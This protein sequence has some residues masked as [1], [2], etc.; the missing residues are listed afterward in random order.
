MNKSARRREPRRHCGAEKLRI[1]RNNDFTVDVE[2]QRLAYFNQ[3]TLGAS[4]S[5][6][7]GEPQE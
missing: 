3:A 1:Q 4:S 6:G 7:I 5:D 2:S